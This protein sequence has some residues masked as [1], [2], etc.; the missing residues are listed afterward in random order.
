MSNRIYYANQQIAFKPNASAS[1]VAAHGVQSV[2]LSTTFTL[3]QA[4]E[5]GQLSIYEN[6]EGVPE[7]EAT[8]NKV[9]D[10]YPPLYLLATSSSADDSLIHRAESTTWMSLGIWPDTTISASGT[11]TQQVEMTGMSV[12]AVSYELTVDSSFTESITLVGNDKAWLYESA[13]ADAGWSL[14]PVAGAFETNNDSPVGTGGVQQRENFNT[15]LSTLPAEATTGNARIQ[16]I[17]ISADISRENIFELGQKKTVARFVNFPV[18]I[19]CDIEVI[20]SSGDMVNAFAQGCATA[21][22]KPC[23]GAVNNTEDRT[24]KITTCEG[25]V[26]DLGSKSRLS[27]VN[28][29]GGDAGGGNATVSYTY[30]TFNDFTVS[31]INYDY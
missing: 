10:G 8:V 26:I 30:T 14:S 24:I 1:W 13:C 4:F 27:S 18:E 25:T 29:G 20:P 28:Y 23:A 2:G 3:E 9:L 11:P 12:T 7:V 19:T 15:A 22:S 16:S 6:I 31:H 5:L 21:L 17:N